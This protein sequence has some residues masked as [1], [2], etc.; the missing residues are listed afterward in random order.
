LIS[1]A[2]LDHARVPK[3]GYEAL[4]AACA[5]VIVVADRL[6]ASVRPGDAFTVDVHVVSDLRTDLGDL[7]C[8]ATLSWPGGAHRWRFAGEIGAD[9]CVRVGS[10]QVEVPDVPDGSV[11]ALDLE[12]TGTGA[13]VTDHDET[14][15]KG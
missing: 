13:V 6:P 5:P 9:A 10:L 3:V 2:V 4:R 8:T 7:G 1:W 15:V 14:L 12:V 11:L